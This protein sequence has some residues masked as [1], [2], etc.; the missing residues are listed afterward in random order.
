MNIIKKILI[1]I[2]SIG[3][4]M[5]CYGAIDT[6]L[7][8]LKEQERIEIEVKLKEAE[9][10]K[11]QEAKDSLIVEVNNYI[12]KIAPKNNLSSEAIIN[13]CIENDINIIFVLAQ[14]Q[15]ESRFG[16][17]GI[18]LKTNSVWNVMSYD[19]WS[20]E[21]IK[22]FGRGYSHPNESIQPYINLLKTRY[23][24]N[25][26]TEEDMM[27]NFIASSGHRYASNP[28]YEYQLKSIYNRIDKQTNI[29]E[30]YN[31]YIKLI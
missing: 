26:K 22:K 31:N 6:Q 7:T 16:T 23:L 30:L 10:K 18:A 9:L 27:N 21:K 19:G 1:G 8:K 29:N 2:G 17:K 5:I 4:L 24:V 25:G 11:Q 12:N 13:A 3:I 20:A 15:L 28:K 14:A